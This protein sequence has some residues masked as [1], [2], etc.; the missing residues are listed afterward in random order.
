MAQCQGSCQDC[1]STCNWKCNSCNGCQTCNASCEGSCQNNKQKV[2]QIS[3]IGSFYF[4]N[5]KSA[6]NLQNDTFLTSDEWNRIL[7]YINKGYSL[8]GNPLSSTNVYTYN[9]LS[10]KAGKEYSNEFMSANMFNGAIAKMRKS[11]VGSETPGTYVKKGGANGDIIYAK[12]FKDLEDYF[13]NEFSV[14]YCNTCN[15]CN[16]CDTS[17]NGC[18]SCNGTCQ[19]CQGNDSCCQ[20]P[21]GQ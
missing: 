9:N 21:L 5:G 14:N 8:T 18:N 19:S 20:T 2:S 15:S 16:G 4:R 17:C 11:T 7:D 13:N 6:I 12:Y 10:I 1:N 3:S